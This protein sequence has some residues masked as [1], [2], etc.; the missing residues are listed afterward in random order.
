V[1]TRG[2]LTGG[3]ARTIALPRT[4][5]KA[6]TYRIDVRLVAQV[7]PGAVTRLTSDPLVVG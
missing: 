2:S 6:G 5:L 1:A 3:A 7:N 4:T